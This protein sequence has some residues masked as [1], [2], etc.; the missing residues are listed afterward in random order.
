VVS[1]SLEP[2]A[3]QSCRKVGNPV[4]QVPF[5]GPVVK[6]A[7]RIEAKVGGRGLEPLTFCV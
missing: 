6:Q 7:A 1:I 4:K 5:F 3:S 2:R